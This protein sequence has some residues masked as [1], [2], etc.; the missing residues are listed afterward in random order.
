MRRRTFLTTPLKPLEPIQPL[1][2]KPIDEEEHPLVNHD[3]D[4]QESLDDSDDDID[5]QL[6][7][8]SWPRNEFALYGYLIVVIFISLLL[9]CFLGGKSPT[10][11]LHIDGIK[12]LIESTPRTRN[13][14]YIVFLS[15]GSGEKRR[16]HV[17]MGKSKTSPKF[18][19][20]KAAAKLPRDAHSYDWVKVDVVTAI[21]HEDIFDH[22]KDKPDVSEWWYGV[23]LDWDKGWVFLPDEVYARALV[24]SREMLRWDHVMKVAQEKKLKGWPSVAVKRSDVKI[25]KEMTDDI[26]ST[27]I[28]IDFFLTK[29]IF[30]D[31]SDPIPEAVPLYHGHRLFSSL[32]TNLLLGVAKEAGRYLSRSVDNSGRMTNK[33]SPRSEIDNNGHSKM[34]HAGGIHSMA[35]LYRVW[36]D[37]ELLGSI[38]KALDWLVQQTHDCPLPYEPH[39]MGK[40]VVDSPEDGIQSTRLDVNSLTLLSLA[41]YM[42][43]SQDPGYLNIAKGIAQ[44]IGGAQHEDGSLVQKQQLVENELDED[45]Q[46]KATLGLAAF[47]LA[48]LHNTVKRLGLQADPNWAEGA[49]RVV[50]FL[51]AKE[52]KVGDETFHY[53]SWTMYAIAEMR[54]WHINEGMVDFAMRAARITRDFQYGDKTAED[55]DRDRIGIFYDDPS[56][57]ETAIYAEGLCAIYGLAVEQGRV[58]DQEL[59]FNSLS[60]AVRYILQAQY[61][62]EQAMYLKN[63]YR[64]MGAFQESIYERQITW[65]ENTQHNLAGILCVAKVIQ[66]YDNHN[67]S[68]L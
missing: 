9:I 21:S 29:S 60:L 46:K 62:P 39:M 23:G 18:A 54:L 42:D 50:E 65:S 4:D 30:C 35:L 68:W 13:E 36:K 37:P 67:N 2:S 17:A 41:E 44:W 52:A 33:Y 43:A 53:D 58:A 48:K 15:R 25:T 63:P 51:V 12:E 38:V 55:Q 56:A 28:Q 14:E 47:A 61:R 22:M 31:L 32:D 57:K 19:L 8:S 24:D 26:D 1:L 10:S 66:A 7:D 59:I 3:S 11:L 49:G 40:C 5:I 45:I 34:N 16:T 20:S 27:K 64:I 6:L